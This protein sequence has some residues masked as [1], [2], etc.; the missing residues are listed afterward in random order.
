MGQV[1]CL[2]LITKIDVVKSKRKELSLSDIVE[3]INLEFPTDLSLFDLIEDDS[4]YHWLIKP[5]IVEQQLLPFLE[6]FYPQYY[7]DNGEDDE[8]ED[9][10]R[11]Q[12]VLKKLQEKAGFDHW[13]AFA[14]ETSET[15]F[16][17]DDIG[18]DYF[19]CENKPY[20]PT[21]E[22]RFE[23]VILALAG[24]VYLETYGGLLRFLAES[25]QLRFKEFPLAK[26]L[27]LYISG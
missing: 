1:I 17:Y 24:K 3:K 7:L 23:G 20:R 6:K 13:L 12:S 26:C 2:S 25:V 19:R 14:K 11:Y 21:L 15:L 27:K 9:A 8:D 10:D 22:V 5:N 4:E 18:V 16:Q